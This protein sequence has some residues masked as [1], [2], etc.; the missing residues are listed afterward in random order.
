MPSVTINGSTNNQYIDS[1]IEVSYTQNTNL[2]TSTVTA[3]LYYKRN[4]TGYT[5]SGTGTFVIYI[6]G[7]ATSVTKSL[8]ITGS[9]WVLAVS[10]SKTVSHNSDGTKT[11]NIDSSGSIP[12]SSLSTT[13]CSGKIN[14]NTI[15]RASTI[16]SASNKTL[17][18]ACSV[19]WT[20]LS[21]DFRYKLKF[22]L[23][24]WSYTTGAIH[25]N[26]TSAY[27]Y[28]GYTLPLDVASQLPND[29]TGMMT[30]ALYTYSNSSATTQV[31]SA[32]SKTFTITIPDNTSTKPAIGMSLEPVHAL[33]S[34]FDGLYIKGYSKVKA[35][36]I[37]EGKYNAD[38]SSYSMSVLGKSYSS[39]Y[40]S[41]Y[42]S[43]SG[44]IKVTGEATDSRGYSN[45]VEQSITV[46]PYVK[47]ALLPASDESK[48][49]CARC[50]ENGNLNESG[51]YLKIKASRSYSK[52][53]ADGVQKNFCEIR[54]RC[55]EEGETFSGDEGW[56][57]LLAG[58]ATSTDTVNETLSEVVSSTETAY[59]VQVGVIDDIGE[60]NVIQFMIPTDF[61]TFDVPE[62]YKGKRIGLFRYAPET[63]EDGL[64]VGKPIFGAYEDYVTEKGVFEVDSDVKG[65][66]R[67]RK[68]KSGALDMN[69]VFKVSPVT[70]TTQAT[71][72]GY[73]SELIEIELPFSVQNFQYTGSPTVYFLFFANANMNGDNKI[74]FRLFRFTDFADLEGKDVYVRIIASGEY[75]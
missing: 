47:P 15:P 1:K 34:K 12:V 44:T 36:L 21:K 32:S 20:P 67:Y 53:T 58:S 30:V 51:T 52:V 18:S 57:T 48:I 45:T 65:S 28:S 26:T 14:L 31:G 46:L 64:Y 13:Y 29:K 39:P 73:W 74:R 6:D 37:G 54:Y 16:T 70:D 25:P 66:W 17:G 62:A 4:N 5:T 7:T 40:Q 27:T 63:G 22:S 55:V 23:E 42:I 41:G 71:D 61:V 60:T 38:I 10:A 69:G 2:N 50:D 49:I 19:K 59:V 75:K 56:V 3:S 9:A 72:K 33:E 11:V 8:S 35:T 24:D 43:S 68:W